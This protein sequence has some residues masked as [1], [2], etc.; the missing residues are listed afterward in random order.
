M[1]GWVPHV[2]PRPRGR[3]LGRQRNEFPFVKEIN[4]QHGAVGPGF[5][6]L[7]WGAGT[8]LPPSSITFKPDL[9][10]YMSPHSGLCPQDPRYRLGESGMVAVCVHYTMRV[11]HL[12]H[13]WPHAWL[14]YTPVSWEAPL[15]PKPREPSSCPITQGHLPRMMYPLSGLVTKE[16]EAKAS[17]S[18]H[19]DIIGIYP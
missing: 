14:F 16:G 15:G 6:I 3:G 4:P 13:A 9:R 10:V 2:S 7:R 11:S 18:P 17:Q 19:A 12:I 5:F 1:C 8:S